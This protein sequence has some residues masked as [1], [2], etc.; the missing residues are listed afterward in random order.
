MSDEGTGQLGTI[1]GFTAFLLFLFLAVHVL[2]GLYATSV[3]TAAALDGA[4]IV[5]GGGVDHDDPAAV[6]AAQAEAEAHVRGLLG[7]AGDRASFDWSGSTAT[8]VALHVR[9]PWP[10]LLPDLGGE[11]GDAAVDR[12]VRMRI[13]RRG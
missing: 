8:E 1:A 12:T 13:E 4:R 11:L 5:A 3:V 2:V 9:V 10:R 7:R 6:E